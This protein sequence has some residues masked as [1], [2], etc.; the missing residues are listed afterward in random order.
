M[1][2]AIRICCYRI[3]SPRSTPGVSVV[4]VVGDPPSRSTATARVDGATGS[5]GDDGGDRRAAGTRHHEDLGRYVMMAIMNVA[6]RLLVLHRGQL[7]T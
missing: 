7:I 3:S 4:S 1:N 2:A 6:Q 5:P